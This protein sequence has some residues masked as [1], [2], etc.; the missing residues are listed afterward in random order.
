MQYM[1]IIH[2]KCN[3][4]AKAHGGTALAI[5][6]NGLHS[7]GDAM[8][9]AGFV[10]DGWIPTHTTNPA[11]IFMIVRHSDNVGVDADWIQA[12]TATQRL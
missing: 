1:C 9:G 4:A 12:N 5:M 2:R 8:A 3:H 11:V 6:G 10:H 7:E